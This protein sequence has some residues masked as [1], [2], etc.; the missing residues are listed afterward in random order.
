MLLQLG[1]FAKIIGVFL[2]KSEGILI[3]GASQVSRLIG[4]YLEDNGRH[5]VLIDSNQTNILLAQELGLEA[6]N[7]D[8]YSETL[9]DNIELNDVGFLMALTG[10]ADINKY[11]INKLRKQFGE[12][13][14]FRLIAADEINNPSS[15]NNGLFSHTDDFNMLAEAARN[16]PNIHEITLKDRDH[17]EALIKNDQ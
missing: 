9:E 12:N 4:R 14:S 6:I 15:L 10:S 5:V 16:H 13:G 17:Y 8:I 11:A 7:T 2:K 3:V 1:F